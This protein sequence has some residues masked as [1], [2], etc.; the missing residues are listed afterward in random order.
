MRAGVSDFCP[1]VSLVDIIDSIVNL[2]ITWTKASSFAIVATPSDMD[3]HK[4]IASNQLRYLVLMNL[5][6]VPP[7][8]SS[9]LRFVED[10]ELQSQ[11]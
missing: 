10:L 5:S 9:A 1:Y 11:R 2:R 4:L 7:S 8:C 6:R 3:L